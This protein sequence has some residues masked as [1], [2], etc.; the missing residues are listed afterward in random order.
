MGIFTRTKDLIINGF[1]A[2]NVPATELLGKLITSITI[3]EDELAERD[4]TL[5]LHS[6]GIW[7]LR[8]KGE[9]IYDGEFLDCTK[10][11]LELLEK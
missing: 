3:P 8:E 5:E 7:Q 2:H 6:Y 4:L 11:A 1:I 10:R 9:V